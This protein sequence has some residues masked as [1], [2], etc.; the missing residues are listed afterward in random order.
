VVLQA[1]QAPESEPDH[2]VAA[3]LAH[4]ATGAIPVQRPATATPDKK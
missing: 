2:S 1:H 4:S 3:S